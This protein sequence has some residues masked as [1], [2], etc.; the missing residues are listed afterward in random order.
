MI[1]G[2][3]F[4]YSFVAV[5]QPEN[6]LFQRHLLCGYG[7]CFRRV[8]LNETPKFYKFTMADGRD[9]ENRVL[10]GCGT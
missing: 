4:E 6:I 7:L 10:A 3:Q 5:S 1:H 2:R 9:N 8:V